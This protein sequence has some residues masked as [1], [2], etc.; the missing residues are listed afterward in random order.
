MRF[1]ILKHSARDIFS[2]I[3]K[4]S[5]IYHKSTWML[6]IYPRNKR[7][8]DFIYFGKRCAFLRA[9]TFL[10]NLRFFVKQIFLRSRTAAS[11]L[12]KISKLWKRIKTLISVLKCPLCDTIG[13]I[14]DFDTFRKAVSFSELK[15][16]WQVS[17]FLSS[18]FFEDLAEK[19]ACLSKEKLHKHRR[20][21]DNIVRLGMNSD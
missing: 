7:F 17:D 10:T 18:K 20:N 3:Y 11:A 19:L 12:A 1:C 8:G 14:Y 5:Q 15:F 21:T 6:N 9:E 16:C 2:Q 4:N 13:V